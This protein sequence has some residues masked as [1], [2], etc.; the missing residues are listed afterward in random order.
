[1]TAGLQSDVFKSAGANFR[2]FY[3]QFTAEFSSSLRSTVVSFSVVT[4]TR[5]FVCTVQDI[6]WLISNE[7]PTVMTFSAVHEFQSQTPIV[8][9]RRYAYDACVNPCPR[10]RYTRGYRF[11]RAAH[12]IQEGMCCRNSVRSSISPHHRRSHGGSWGM[13]LY[14]T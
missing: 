2:T 4:N 14:R 12:C 7:R 9:Y 5:Q 6:D 11:Y 13:N 8:I 3:Y 10:L 1:M